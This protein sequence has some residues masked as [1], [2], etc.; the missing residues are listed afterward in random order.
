MRIILI[1]IGLAAVYCHGRIVTSVCIRDKQIRQFS[2]FRRITKILHHLLECFIIIEINQLTYGLLPL[3][4]LMIIPE[5][6][7][8]ETLRLVAVILKD[9]NIT[10]AEGSFFPRMLSRIRPMFRKEITKLW[11]IFGILGVCQEA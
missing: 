11:E 5:R 1:Y 9:M 8:R 4:Y 6:A 10:R 3:V 2:L 7:K